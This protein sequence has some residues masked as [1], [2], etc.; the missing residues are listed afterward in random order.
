MDSTAKE[1]PFKNHALAFNKFLTLVCQ[2]I[3]FNTKYKLQ[4]VVIVTTVLPLPRSLWYAAAT[5]RCTPVSTDILCVKRPDKSDDVLK[6]WHQSEN[7]SPSINA[8]LLEERSGRR[9]SLS[10]FREMMSRPPPWK[11]DKLI[12][13]PTLSVN[14]YLKKN[15]AKFHPDQI[16]KNGALCFFEEHCPQK[17]Q[18]Q[19]E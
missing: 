3:S 19:D 17:E 14:A 5:A 8:Y 1:V 11:Y 4:M 13:N 6:V 18:Q 2:T 16:W 10:P 15:H 12:R 9:N 7:P